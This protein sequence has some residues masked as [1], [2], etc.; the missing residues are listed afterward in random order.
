MAKPQIDEILLEF[1]SVGEV[2]E[3]YLY[4]NWLFCFC[5]YT[6]QGKALNDTKHSHILKSARSYIL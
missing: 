5:W 3:F 2:L 1:K 4:W 6:A